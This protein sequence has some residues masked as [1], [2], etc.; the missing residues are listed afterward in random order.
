MQVEVEEQAERGFLGEVATLRPHGIRARVLA[1]LVH[2]VHVNVAGT[3]DGNYSFTVST[4]KGQRPNDPALVTFDATGQTADQI[5][6]GLTGGIATSVQVIDGESI[7][8]LTNVVRGTANLVDDDVEIVAV[9]PGKIFT[10]VIV[11]NPGGNLTQNIEV[12]ATAVMV[13]L[14]IA[15]VGIDDDTT[16]LPAPGDTAGQ[17]LGVL[18][19][20]KAAQMLDTDDRPDGTHE[21]GDT[22]EIVRA[23]DIWVQP[24]GAVLPNDPVFVRT[25]ATGN[26]QAGAF[27]ASQDGTAQITTGTPTAVNDAVYELTVNIP[28]QFGIAAMTRVFVF[29]ADASATPTEISAGFQAKMALDAAFTARI[30]ASGAATLVLTGQE[31]GISF[32]VEDTQVGAGDWASITTG[33]PAV[34]DC[35]QLDSTVARWLTDGS[36]T[37]V[38]KLSLNLA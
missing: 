30:V 14:G 36:G 18:R 2:E 1:K 34:A 20:G 37:L 6:T 35:V 38:A 21:D 8:L 24:E 16:R 26:E 17:L 15:M 23:G 7:P 25:T 4:A 33:T 27:R 13:P 12:N 29:T 11:G 10:V 3:T 28:E 9:Q 19:R 5:T 32:T 31:L 22:L